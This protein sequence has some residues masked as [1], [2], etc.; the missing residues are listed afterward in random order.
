MARYGN[1]RRMSK[2]GGRRSSRRWGISRGRN[3]ECI[4]NG[5]P[6]NVSAGYDCCSGYCNMG[7]EYGTMEGMCQER[8]RKARR[9]PQVRQSGGRNGNG[10][11]GT[12]WME[13]DY[14]HK[15]GDH[16]ADPWFRQQGGRVNNR[17]MRRGGKANTTNRFSGRTQTNPKGRFKK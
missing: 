1:G 16:E 17:K 9:L 8:K 3:R 5:Q 6:C 12:G 13:K 2:R 10:N 4:Q 7:T 14:I 11:G 15:W